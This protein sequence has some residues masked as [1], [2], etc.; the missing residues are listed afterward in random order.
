MISQRG[1]TV[2]C[3]EKFLILKDIHF[4][5]HFATIPRV[6]PFSYNLRKER[7]TLSVLKT[8]LITV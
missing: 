5:I 6:K 7:L 3:S 8:L 2:K 4:A 1:K